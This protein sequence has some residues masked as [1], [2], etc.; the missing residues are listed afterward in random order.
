MAVAV[1][2][3]LSFA[4]ILTLVMVPTLYSI[5]DDFTRLWGWVMK[6]IR[7]RK[8]AAATAKIALVGLALGAVGQARAATLAE[9]TA[10]AERHSTDVRL[11]SEATIQSGT[12]RGQAWSTLHPRVI[13]NASMNFNQYEQSFDP[14]DMIPA[15]FAD[16]VSDPGEPT[17]IQPKQY[18][19]ASLTVQQTLF[20]GPALPLLRG[21]Y[22]THA[23]AKNDERA[24]RQQVRSGVARA[25]YGLGAGRSA[26]ALAEQSVALAEGQLE[27]ATRQVDAGLADRR[28]LLQAQLRV[29][30]ATRDLRARAEALVELEDSFHRLTGLPRDE[31]LTEPSSPVAPASLEDAL[32]DARAT[33]P[34]VA[35]MHDRV[36]IARNDTMGQRL[37]WAPRV[38][39][40]WTY[41]WTE[42]TGFGNNNTFWTA[43]IEGSW[44][45]WDGGLR[46]AQSRAAASRHRSAQLSLDD[47]IDRAESQVRVSWER[48]HRA[49]EAV[50]AVDI[51]ASLAA[52]NHE[53]TNR[54]F[55]AGSATWLEVQ[56]AELAL[57]GA[58][59]TASNERMNRDL[60][61]ID[62][63]VSA[64]RF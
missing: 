34:D 2:F 21:A 13:G 9:A 25:Y 23:A 10:A 36:T 44:T 19:Q 16:L 50:K 62:L 61:A 11:V 41:V 1:I 29:S 38:T 4:T 46:M 32:A 28:A 26:V 60:A 40:N 42:N 17:I 5:Y 57:T 54:A 43:A 20:S 31:P 18:A 45:L 56:Q 53:L 12:M 59:L 55:A 15:E 37:Q 39:A 51:E 35:A 3:G 64:G 52:E 63:L 22:A 27:L 48:Y 58:R 7:P 24:A 49:N 8:L 47:T 14:S 30:Q 33:R 6:S